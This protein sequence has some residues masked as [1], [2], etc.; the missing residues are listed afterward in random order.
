MAMVRGAGGRADRRRRLVPHPPG[1]GG[2][3]PALRGGRRRRGRA[4]DAAAGGDAAPPRRASRPAARSGGRWRSTRRGCS[5][6]RRGRLA[7]GAPADLVLFDP[8]APFVLDRATLRSKS[9]NTPYDLR[10]MQGRVLRTWVGGREVFAAEARHDAARP[11]PAPLAYLLGSIPFGVLITRALGLGDLR[12]HRLGQH[13]RDQR[14]PDRQQGR[15]GGD[16]AARRR[17]GR[18]GGAG[19]RARSAGETAAMV[20][21]LAAFLGHLFPV[22][23]RF[24]GGKGVATFLGVMLALA[25]PVGLDRLRHLARRGGGSRASRRSRRSS[26]RPR[27]RS[28]WRSSGRG[29][30]SGWRWRWR[31]WSSCATAPTSPGCSPATEPRIGKR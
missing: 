4:R 8:D 10:R 27:R 28:G 20:A 24:R 29:R 14:A 3:A 16:A 15:G 31:R 11:D 9:K 12:A 13:R 7:P 25:W 19:R 21:G 22:W 1:R 18:G 26:P 23:L 30:R 2:E 5:G 6:C 17:Q